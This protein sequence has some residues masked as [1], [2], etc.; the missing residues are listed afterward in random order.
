MSN[1]RTEVRPFF[2]LYSRGEV[3]AEQIGDFTSQWHAAPDSEQ[4]SLAPYLGMTQEEYDVFLMDP[5]TL[6]QILIA[7]RPGR[8]LV[9]AIADYVAQ[10]RLA[11]PPEDETALHALGH[12]LGRRAA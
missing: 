6:P 2:E 8:S 4:R 9:Q 11:G 1:I 12:W 3:S 10:L 5:A 7:R